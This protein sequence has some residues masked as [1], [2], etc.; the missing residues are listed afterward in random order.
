MAECGERGRLATACEG[1]GESRGPARGAWAQQAARSSAH[2]RLT[3]A[4]SH[5]AP[6]LPARPAA[7]LRLHW[8][9]WQQETERVRPSEDIVLLGHTGEQDFMTRMPPGFAVERG[10][11]AVGR[12]LCASPAQPAAARGCRH[13]RPR[14]LP[15]LPGAPFQWEVVRAGVGWPGDSSQPGAEQ[16]DRQ[17][18]AGRGGCRGPVPTRSGPTS[19]HSP[20]ARTWAHGGG[21][22]TR[23]PRSKFS[24]H[25]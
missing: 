21:R 15:G 18:A 9:P 23:H 14:L 16:R 20:P 4:L 8:L 17:A 10:A 6:W 5:R 13:R 2:S 3:E 1:P 7:A 24:G 25:T 19:V 11:R 12:G 22:D